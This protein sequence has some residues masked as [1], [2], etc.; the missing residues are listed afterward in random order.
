MLKVQCSAYIKKIIC[1]LVICIGLSACGFHLRG[2]YHLPPSLQNVWVQYDKQ[3]F[4]PMV[5]KIKRSLKESGVTLASDE[6]QASY[7][8]RINDVNQTSVLQSTSTTT[9]VSTYVLNYTLSF[10]VTDATGKDILPVQAVTSSTTYI[11]NSAEALN[12]MTEQ[13]Q[14]LFGLQQDVIFQMM[15]RLSSNNAKRAFS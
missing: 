7:I 3:P 6:A 5:T 1:L 8:F 2:A 15:N 9:Q 13:P 12:N 4:D 11:I 10:S 14:L